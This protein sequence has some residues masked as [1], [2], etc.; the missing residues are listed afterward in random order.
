MMGFFEA[1][2]YFLEEELSDHSP[3]L[4]KLLPE[5]SKVGGLF[6]YCNFWSQAQNFKTLVAQSWQAL[7]LGCAMFR[8]V[9]KLTRQK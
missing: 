8:V 3:M 6:R 9:K 5:I 7:V 2:A 1:E 4:V